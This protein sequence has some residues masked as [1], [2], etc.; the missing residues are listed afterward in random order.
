MDVAVITVGDELLSGTTENTNATWIAAQLTEQ[1]VAV[2]RILVLPDDRETIAARVREYSD[3]FDAV[4]VTGGIGGTP[5]D[6]TMEAVAD[7]FDREMIVSDRALVDVHDRLAELDESIPDLDVDVEAEASIPAGSQPILNDEGLAPGCRLENV[8]VLPGIPG[9]MKAMFRDVAEDFEGDLVA[10]TLYTVQ[11]E[12][13]IIP[14]LRGVRERFGVRVGCYPDHDAGHNRLR[15]SGTDPDA[16]ADATAWLLETVDA[17][18]TPVSR[19]WDP[20]NRQTE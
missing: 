12:A 1:G 2:E 4:I 3:A 14:H 5:D 15:L 20:D 7:A 13:N 11:P 9:E 6:L 18:E 17:S 8:S 19:D 10:E 16:V